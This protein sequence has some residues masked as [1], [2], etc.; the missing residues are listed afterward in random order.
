MEQVCHFRLILLIKIYRGPLQSSDLDFLLSIPKNLE[1]GTV[2][3][4]IGSDYFWTIV[5]T[6]KIILPSKIGYI[7]TGSY[8]IRSC[9]LLFCYDTS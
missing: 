4:L 6:D 8:I 7:L 9:H 5:G 3:L 2:D 1:L